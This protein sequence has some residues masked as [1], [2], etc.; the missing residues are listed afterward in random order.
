MEDDFLEPGDD[1]EETS[2]AGSDL[3]A[4]IFTCLLCKARILNEFQAEL[5]FLRPF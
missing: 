4:P 3:D 2:D 5:T 1:S